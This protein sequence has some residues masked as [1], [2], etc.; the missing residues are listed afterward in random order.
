[1]TACLLKS[2][3]IHTNI[4]RNVY[5]GEFTEAEKHS[6]TRLTFGLA[7]FKKKAFVS[8]NEWRII[9]PNL[10]HTYS[11]DKLIKDKYIFIDL[12]LKSIAKIVV[13]PGFEQFRN[14]DLVN[15]IAQQH[16]VR[17]ELDYSRIPL[18]L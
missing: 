16:G 12:N 11:K 13:G 18:E 7:H 10:S 15:E 6:I 3:P 4:L 2:T 9:S 5:V 14:L 8:E 1:M 17:A